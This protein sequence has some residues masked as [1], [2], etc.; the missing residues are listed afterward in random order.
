MPVQNGAPLDPAPYAAL[1]GFSPFVPIL[2]HFPAGVDVAAS[3]APRLLAERRTYDGRSL[4]PDS[5]TVL[6]DADTGERVVHFI[7]QDARAT[8]GERQVTFLQP[9]KSLT[10]GHRYIVAVRG[11]IDPTGSPVTAEPAFAALRDGRPT[12]IASLETRREHFEEL[13]TRLAAEGIEREDL[14]LAFDFVVRSDAALTGDLVFMRDQAFAWLADQVDAGA[15][16][17][18]VTSTGGCEAG[19]TTGWKRIEGTFQAPLFLDRDPILD[20]TSAGDLTTNSDGMPVWRQLMNAPFAV[21]IPCAA[22]AGGS[23]P[24]PPLLAGH[25]GFDT[26]KLL[27]DY[28]VGLE[29]GDSL[30]RF[31]LGATNWLGYSAGDL[32][33]S[34]QGLQDLN[35]SVALGTRTL[36]GELNTLVLARMLKQA[37][38]NSDEEFRT[39]DGHGVLPGASEEMFFVGASSGGGLGLTFAALSPDVE[40]V[41]IETPHLF[42]VHFQRTVFYYDLVFENTVLP[43]GVGDSMDVALLLSVNSEQWIR[44][45]GA[46]FMTHVTRDPLPGANAK[47]VLLTLAWLDQFASATASAMPA[48]RRSCLEACVAIRSILRRTSA[49]N[50]SYPRTSLIVLRSP[51]RLT[52]QLFSRTLRLVLRE[53][54][55]A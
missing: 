18:T 53:Q 30:G 9:G 39:A 12:D 17:F 24:L 35:L 46:S 25:G 14:I 6:L 49:A 19:V 22:L 40:R 10:P 48:T 37:L 3:N 1:D 43:T 27:L 23:A 31:V 33:F 5:P 36:Q 16:T 41:W 11:L 4:E 55:V 7:E 38:F 20:P 26:G 15:Q 32:L 8:G 42:P 29:N 45:T 52:E 28:I 2:M 44:G 54:E 50:E 13:F 51:Y 21:A 34:V 47:K